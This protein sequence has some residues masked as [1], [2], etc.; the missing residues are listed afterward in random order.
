[1]IKLVN[2]IRTKQSCAWTGCVYW[3]LC[4]FVP[5][6][7]ICATPAVAATSTSPLVS[8]GTAAE[9]DIQIS[10]SVL[11]TIEKVFTTTTGNLLTNYVPSASCEGK[12][13]IG[14]SR[15]TVPASDTAP[16]LVDIRTTTFKSSTT[17]YA[18]FA[19]MNGAGE[20]IL[21]EDF[22]SYTEDTSSPYSKCTNSTPRTFGIWNVTQ[23]DVISSI[24][25]VTDKMGSQPVVLQWNGGGISTISA[26]VTH[27]KVKGFNS[28]TCKVATTN[29]SVHYAVSYSTDSIHW[30]VL[31]EPEYSVQ[32]ALR[33]K[34]SPVAPV[35]AYVRFQITS[36][37]STGSKYRLYIDSVQL[38]TCPNQCF[39]TNYSTEK[40]DL[41]STKA[42]M[43]F[44]VNGGYEDIS[45]EEGRNQWITLPTPKRGKV[46]FSGWKVTDIAN[47]TEVFPAGSKYLLNSDVTLQA[48]WETQQTGSPLDIVDW[49]PDGVT[50]N[51][52]GKSVSK[53]I[54]CNDKSLEQ[55]NYS[56]DNKAGDRTFFIPTNVICSA[57]SSETSA[58]A[59]LQEQSTLEPGKDVLLDV[60]WNYDANNPQTSSVGYYRVPYI[61][62]SENVE[63]ST[64]LTKA[65][66]I[67]VR[68]GKAVITQSTHVR[69]IY[70]YPNAELEVREGVTLQCRTIYLRTRP[71][72]TAVFTNHG[73]LECQQM[74]YTRICADRTAY[75]QLALPFSSCIADMRLTTGESLEYGTKWLVKQY[76]AQ[77][78][79][80]QGFGATNWV[81]LEQ[82]SLKA[83]IGYSML[84]GSNWYREYCFP[85]QYSQREQSIPVVAHTGQA[86]QENPVH[87]G[88]NYVCLPSTGRYVSGTGTSPE[89]AVK[90]SELR[91]DNCTYWQHVV[92]QIDPAKP[93]YYQAAQTGQLVLGETMSFA[94]TTSSASLMPRS[95][96][97]VQGADVSTQWLQLS[98]TDSA[99]RADEAN[100]YLHPTRFDTCY[101]PQYDLVK[102]KGYGLRPMLYSVANQRELSFNALPDTIGKQGICMGYYA[103]AAC[104]MTMA[105][106]R[107]DYLG[108]LQHVYLLDRETNIT[109]DLLLHD[110]TFQS[111]AG[112]FVSRFAVQ[113]RFVSDVSTSVSDDATSPSAPLKLW[114][115]G[116]L[117][118]RIGDRL[119]DTWG[120]PCPVSL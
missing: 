18:V 67:V 14:W 50:I 93:F 80:E 105:V 29:S 39:Y 49:S 1:M 102:M 7:C 34:S 63:V 116:H 87:A 71:F 31:H 64:S 27:H 53:G 20:N 118:I 83:G 99:G 36:A 88:W 32:S 66:D 15:T 26:M 112:E 4:V 92:T 79:A 73:T 11:G 47:Y 100:I 96:T 81:K 2:A 97:D 111:Q 60:R 77:L 109:T 6:I 33:I 103:P 119:Y 59:T 117:Y 114:R 42:K 85:V 46:P 58:E 52:S 65:D 101:M 94:P 41:S 43:Q 90:V 3:C 78:R 28:F 86:A 107:N 95:D 61:Y 56:G 35:D 110:Y 70:V 76:D 22:D 69:N 55:T 91:E 8:A 48:Q 62:A 54:Q 19:C 75:Y 115:D 74:Y 82:D 12:V 25:T 9:S 108:R 106:C 5:L 45:I 104:T 84:S 37:Q 10:F 38:T 89:S 68:S 13:F 17:L 98:L 57:P 30:K 72:Q 120:R 23:G 21:F 16:E 24:K 51:M 113:C 44:D 40:E